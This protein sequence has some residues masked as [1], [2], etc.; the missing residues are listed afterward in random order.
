MTEHKNIHEAILAIY[1]EVGYVQKQKGETLNYTFAGEGAFIRELRP[2][3]IEH[4]VTVS[5]LQ[6]DNLLQEHYITGKYDTKMVRS[7]AHG[8]VRFTHV[9][10]TF[11]DVQSYGEGSDAGDKSLNKAMTDLYKYAIRQT[12]MIETG[13]DPDK[14]R[15]ENNDTTNESATQTFA[16]ESGAVVKSVDPDKKYKMLSGEVV[17]MVAA[18]L[19]LSSQDAVKALNEMKAAGKIQ[20]E[21][22]MEHYENALK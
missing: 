11:I 19:G 12:F 8:I 6:M 17:K 14:E 5:V 9:S 13:D 18:R 16:K 10:G 22:V 1:K 7:T 20:A 3:M 2:A 15:P 21:G 4:G